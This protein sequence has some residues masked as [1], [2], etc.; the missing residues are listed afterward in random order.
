MDGHAARR[1]KLNGKVTR[2]CDR[3][4]SLT[5]VIFFRAGSPPYINLSASSQPG[6]RKSLPRKKYW[7]I[8]IAT[9]RKSG[10]RTWVHF[11]LG[12]SC[13][14]TLVNGPVK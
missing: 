3:D 13:S 10:P 14:L 4:K 11:K 1:L 8:C 9:K 6:A 2:V 12:T 5:F 7:G